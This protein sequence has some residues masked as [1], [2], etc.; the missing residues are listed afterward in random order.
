MRAFHKQQIKSQS[1]SFCTVVGL[2]ISIVEIPIQCTVQSSSEFFLVEWG[3]VF[4]K[5][6]GNIDI[7]I[8]KLQ[9]VA[10]NRYYQYNNFVHYRLILVDS[11]TKNSKNELI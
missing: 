4:S 7:L 3:K 11:D 8:F 9:G 10:K 1:I 6:I 5:Y 2:T